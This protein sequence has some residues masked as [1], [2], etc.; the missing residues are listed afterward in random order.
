[1]AQD[2]FL[3]Y[4]EDIGSSA[5]GSSLTPFQPQEN[6]EDEDSEARRIAED[7]RRRFA[8]LEV[9]TDD[10]DSEKHIGFMGLL[11]SLPVKV[12]LR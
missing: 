8:P 10:D 2:D 6:L 11:Y 4:G 1:M 7:I 3:D 9:E 12:R 5:R